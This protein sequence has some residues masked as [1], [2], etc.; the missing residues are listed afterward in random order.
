M[1]KIICLVLIVTMML[2]ACSKWNVE[3]VE[4]TEPS[5]SEAEKLT[6]EKEPEFVSK[7]EEKEPR[8]SSFYRMKISE[9][10]AISEDDMLNLRDDEIEK[11]SIIFQQPHWIEAP[12]NFIVTGELLSPVNMLE[13]P[14]KNGTLYIS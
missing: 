7:E 6:E 1:K 13:S 3:I 2:T 5:K 12:E 10:E 9:G 14:A 11:L 8:I 4:P